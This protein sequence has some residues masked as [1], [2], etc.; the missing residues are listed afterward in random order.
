MLFCE[1]ESR[2][3]VSDFLLP[4]GLYSPW[5]SLDQNTTRVGSHSNVILIYI[6]TNIEEGYLFSTPSSAFIVCRLFDDGHSP[7]V[8][9]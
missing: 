2:S 4:H 5:N 9:W 6:P 3:V 8:R 1:S 7:S